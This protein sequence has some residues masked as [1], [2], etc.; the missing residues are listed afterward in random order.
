MNAPDYYTPPTSH[1]RQAEMDSI[2]DQ[3]DAAVRRMMALESL[4]RD[5]TDQEETEYYALELKVY[6]LDQNLNSIYTGE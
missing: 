5:Y 2:Q 1:P 6:E 4:D 3:I